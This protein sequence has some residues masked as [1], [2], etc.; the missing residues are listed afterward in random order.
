MT[1]IL[2]SSSRKKPWSLS[3]PERRSS[4]S[5]RRWLPIYKL[6]L[7]NHKVPDSF[8]VCPISWRRSRAVFESYNKQQQGKQQ[9]FWSYI[10]WRIHFLPLT[11]SLCQ[12]VRL[13]CVVLC[14]ER[15]ND[16]NHR[17]SWVQTQR[18]QGSLIS[19]HLPWISR[20]FRVWAMFSSIYLDDENYTNGQSKNKSRCYHSWI[21]LEKL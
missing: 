4:D 17:R 10:W 15:H 1:Q 12:R 7:F 13:S 20:F 3:D 5:L 14:S 6:Y 21:S 19:D 16:K 8:L 11:K 9:R 18:I 2:S